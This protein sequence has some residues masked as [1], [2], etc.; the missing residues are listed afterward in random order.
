MITSGVLRLKLAR[1]DRIEED[2][3]TLVDDDGMP[4]HLAPNLKPLEGQW[5][6]ITIEDRATYNARGK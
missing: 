3:F 6:Y 5:V 4:F 1:R 2:W